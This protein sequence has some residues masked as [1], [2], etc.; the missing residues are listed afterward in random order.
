MARSRKT[1]GIPGMGNEAYAAAM[2]GL[3]SSGA[4]GVHGDRRERRRRTRLARRD[5]A[6]KQSRDG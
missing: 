4:A 5:D 2:R 3:R 1:L 6:I